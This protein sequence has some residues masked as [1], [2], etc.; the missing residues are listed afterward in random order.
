MR[1][2][3]PNC[4]HTFATDRGVVTHSYDGWSDD[5][6]RMVRESIEAIRNEGT[7]LPLHMDEPGPIVERWGLQ[8]TLMDLIGVL[9]DGTEFPQA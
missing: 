4:N 8:G 3:C 9:A 1:A 6:L 7:P 2:R 5:E